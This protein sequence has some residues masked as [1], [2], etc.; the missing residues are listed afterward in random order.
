MS[1]PAQVRFIEWVRSLHPA[2]FK[3]VSVLDCGSMDING[4]CRQFFTDVSY[5]GIDV[6][7]GPNVDE[8]CPAYAYKSDV[9]FD[10]IISTEMLEHSR[11]WRADVANMYQLLRRGGLLI[12]T[13]AAPGRPV[14]GTH[15]E[16]PQDSPH[17]LDYYKNVSIA[18]FADNLQ[19]WMFSTFFVREI[20]CDLQFFGIKA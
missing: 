13:C 4:N 6:G 10:T 7:H 16:K 14:H 19:P 15:A 5:V 18:D 2:H 17:T 1:H 9:F 11:T 3:N 8:V 20:E 12:V